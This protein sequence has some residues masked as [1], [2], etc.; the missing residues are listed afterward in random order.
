MSSPLCLFETSALLLSGH[1]PLSLGLTQIIKDGF[2]ILRLR[3]FPSDP[4]STS[5]DS[6]GG[7]SGPSIPV[8]LRL[9]FHS[10]LSPKRAKPVSPFTAHGLLDMQVPG[11]V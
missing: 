7:F 6:F 9:W 11:Q 4:Q 1:L 5:W 10:V 8:R 3:A 2:F